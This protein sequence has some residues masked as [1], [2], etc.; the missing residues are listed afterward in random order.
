MPQVYILPHLCTTCLCSTVSLFY[1]CMLHNVHVSRLC[2]AVS[3][4][5]ISM[6]R[7]TCVPQLFVPLCLLSTRLCSTVH[8][9]SACLRSTVFVFHK[10]ISHNVHIPQACVP[11][12]LR[13]T[14]L[15]SAVSVSH[16]SMFYSVCVPE[17]YVPPCAYS[18]RLC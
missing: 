17:V 15:R 5:R 13:S 6:F 2:C 10:S 12:C 4:F 1:K 7:G 16:K 11:P 3:V 18:T 8:V 14:R 9:C